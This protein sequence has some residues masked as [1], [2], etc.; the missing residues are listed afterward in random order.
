[1]LV[2]QKTYLFSKIP[3]VTCCKTSL[4]TLCPQP[5]AGER[6]RERETST[7]KSGSGW[8]ATSLDARTLQPQWGLSL[9][10]PIMGGRP[11]PV[12]AELGM[13]GRRAVRLIFPLHS[14]SNSSSSIQ[15]LPSFESVGLTSTPCQ[16]WHC[17]C[18]FWAIGEVLWLCLV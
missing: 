3:L 16:L 6:E 5:M 18:A 15:L 11:R 7:S 4:M 2:V 17:C 12:R 14:P 8:R 9:A 13:A 10:W 1:M